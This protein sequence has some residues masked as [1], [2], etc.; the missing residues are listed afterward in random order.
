MSDAND[1]S[2]R[3]SAGICAILLGGFGV[4]KFILG[5]TT[6]GFILL[7]STLLTCG[8]GAAITS[9]IGLA[10]GIIYLTKTDEEFLN[11]YVVNKKS[12]F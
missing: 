6:E 4:H 10:E 2:K 8:I 5:Y 9:V 3:T 12:W 11:T 1:S 7:A